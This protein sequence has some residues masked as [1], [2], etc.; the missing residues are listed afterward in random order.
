MIQ[1]PNFEENR[2]N[3]EVVMNRQNFLI[4]KRVEREGEREIRII[5]KMTPHVG[6]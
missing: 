3:F 5:L 6:E 1:G 4:A 2:R